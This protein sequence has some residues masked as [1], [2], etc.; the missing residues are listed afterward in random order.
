LPPAERVVALRR[1]GRAVD[2]RVLVKLVV[3]TLVTVVRPAITVAR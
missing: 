3:A 2:R 1:Q